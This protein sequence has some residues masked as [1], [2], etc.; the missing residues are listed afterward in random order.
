MSDFL[1]KIDSILT[2]RQKIVV[3]TGLITIGFLFTTQTYVVIFRKYYVIFIFAFFAY[4]LSLWA[5]REGMTKTK[6]ITLLILPVFYCLAST[7]FYFLFQNIRW[8]TRVPVAI[9]FGLN[10]YL[11]LLSQNVFNVAS[12]RAIPLYRAA[13]TANFVYSIFTMILLDSIVFSFNLPFF[14]NMLFVTVLCFPLFLQILWSVKIEKIS[15]QI[16]VYAS[17]LSL[18]IGESALA[19]S[20]WSSAP[21]VVALYL[22]SISYGLLGILLEFLKDRLNKKTVIEYA[23]VGGALFVC[24]FLITNFFN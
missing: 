3:A 5:L 12:E 1:S 14:I 7:S 4:V 2:K 8:L 21:L 11:L 10:F 16:L 20:F 15:G 18:L 19:F 24:I 22:N 9:F 6:S 23:G 13:S 17:I